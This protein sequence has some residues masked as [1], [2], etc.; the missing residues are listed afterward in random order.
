MDKKIVTFYE[1]EIEEYEFHQYKS[2]ISIN[3]K[4]ISEMVVSNKFP[5]VKQDFKYFI[6]YKY[7]KN[8][9]I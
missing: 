2:S 5:F 8:I 7:N 4:D 9:K 1:T 6:G 3:D